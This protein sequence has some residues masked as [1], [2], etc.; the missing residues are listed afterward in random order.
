[1]FAAVCFVV[2][3]F[4]AISTGPAHA[5]VTS[6]FERRGLPRNPQQ[7]GRLPLLPRHTQGQERAFG[8]CAKMGIRESKLVLGKPFDISK[9]GRYAKLLQAKRAK[10]AGIDLE[11]GA[12]LQ[13]A[14][15][16]G[17]HDPAGS[18]LSHP[19][20]HS[21]NPFWPRSSCLIW[22]SAFGLHALPGSHVPLAHRNPHSLSSL[23]LSLLPLRLGLVRPMHTHGTSHTRT[24]VPFP[25]QT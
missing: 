5:L 14:M 15:V 6:V 20:L 18:A 1:M 13:A 10:A 22:P 2:C 21:N 8:C 19:R 16:S 4:V 25:P 7:G 9:I 23:P 12:I 24:P 3:N 11:W 17:P